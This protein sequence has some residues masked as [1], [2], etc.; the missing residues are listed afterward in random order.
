MRRSGFETSALFYNIESLYVIS[1]QKMPSD[2]DLRFFS[3]EHAVV[4]VKKIFNG[5]AEHDSHKIVLK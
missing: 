2:A 3:A 5:F 4:F 1:V